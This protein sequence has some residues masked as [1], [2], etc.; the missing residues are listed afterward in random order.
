MSLLFPYLS[1]LLSS[2]FRVPV[3]LPSRVLSSVRPS[4]PTLLVFRNGDLQSLGGEPSSPGGLRNA[5]K[6]P[7]DV[8]VK[9]G[10]FQGGFDGHFHFYKWMPFPLVSI[11]EGGVRFPVHP[12]LRSCLSTW[13]LCPFQLMPNGFNIIM[14]IAEL[15]NIFDINLGVYDIKDAYDI[16]KSAGGEDTYYLRV[17]VK[18]RPLVIALED[19]SKYAG[20]E[21]LLVSGNWEF[22]PSETEVARRIQISWKLGTPPS[23]YSSPIGCC[24][25]FTI[26]LPS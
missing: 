20:D 7:D 17:K 24:I 1:L 8:L 10:D 4:F 9:S 25:H 23:K 6:I 2:T 16:C 13:R 18:C 14:G 15:N 11:I 5:Y 26:I 19:S 3:L 22:R 21:R 12:L